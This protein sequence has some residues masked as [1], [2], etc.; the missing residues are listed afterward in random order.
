MRDSASQRLS[1]EPV[2]TGMADIRIGTDDDE[3]LPN[4]AGELIPGTSTVS[5]GMSTVLAAAH[6]LP[7]PQ[8]VP[9]AALSSGPGLA[10]SSTSVHGPASSTSSPPASIP[11]PAES[12][13][14]D[15]GSDA[16]A[17]PASNGKKG[18]KGSRK[19]KINL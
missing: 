16:P 13:S 7:A 2:T 12:L 5:H 3:E 10:S 8:I 19:S 6:E 18:K 14:R 4:L 9:A 11:S 15:A 17:V 1:M